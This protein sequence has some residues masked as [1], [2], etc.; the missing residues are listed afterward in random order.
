MAFIAI[1][2]TNS[3]SI[4]K[5]ITNVLLTLFFMAMTVIAAAV[6]FILWRELISFVLEVFEEVRYRAF[7]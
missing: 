1:R 6:L 2:E 3:Y 4:P 7:T 5:T